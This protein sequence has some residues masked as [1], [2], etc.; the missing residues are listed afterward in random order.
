MRNQNFKKIPSAESQKHTFQVPPLSNL[1]SRNINCFGK[2]ITNALVFL[3][4]KTIFGQIF[5]VLGLKFAKNNQKSPLEQKI[6]LENFRYDFFL[7]LL[8]GAFAKLHFAAHLV[9]TLGQ[10]WERDD[11]I[12]KKKKI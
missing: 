11:G 6:E 8:G 9:L 10:P 1:R 4:G 3:V 12:P 5:D 2:N 7:R